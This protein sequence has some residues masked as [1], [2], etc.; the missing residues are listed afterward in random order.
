ME[1]SGV[2]I[3][4][5]IAALAATGT[6]YIVEGLKYIKYKV[7]PNSKWPMKLRPMKWILA[8]ALGGLISALTAAA[9]GA[10]PATLAAVGAAVGGGTGVG[11]LAAREKEP[12]SRPKTNEAP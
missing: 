10:D 3:Q 12:H 4:E 6:P 11:Y 2:N 7:L 9:T 8:A 5:M 1:L